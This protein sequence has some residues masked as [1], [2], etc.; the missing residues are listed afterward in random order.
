MRLMAKFAL[1]ENQQPLTLKDQ[2][3]SHLN[4]LFNTIWDYGAFQQGFG[5]SKQSG[6]L[7]CENELEKLEA[8]MA[9]T[10]EK[11]EPRLK[12]A[13]VN[14]CYRAPN[15]HFSVSGLAQNERLEFSFYSEPM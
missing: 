8:I 15:W 7:L 12:Q 5:L 11:F 2:I 6:D 9:S 10:I 13:K 1:L 4:H 14:I 3:T